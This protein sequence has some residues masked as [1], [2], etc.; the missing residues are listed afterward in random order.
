MTDVNGKKVSF[1]KVTNEVGRNYKLEIN[2]DMTLVTAEM[3]KPKLADH[4]GIDP[5]KQQ[6]LFKGTEISDFVS[7]DQL[8]IRP[9]DEL[10]LTIRPPETEYYTALI[11]DGLISFDGILKSIDFQ[12]ADL[13][14]QEKDTKLKL[15]RT[16]AKSLTRN[17]DLLRE[18]ITCIRA[19]DQKQHFIEQLSTLENEV[20]TRCWD[21]YKVDGSA[22]DTTSP[23]RVNPL[24]RL[25]PAQLSDLKFSNAMALFLQQISHQYEVLVTKSITSKLELCR[26]AMQIA[27]LW[28]A[29][30]TSSNSPVELAMMEDMCSG[31]GRHV[32]MYLPKIKSQPIQNSVE[33]VILYFGNLPFSPPASHRSSDD[34]M[35]LLNSNTATI[36]TAT[37]AIDA[38]LLS[39]LRPPSG[40]TRMQAA[41]AESS[42]SSTLPSKVSDKKIRN[43]NISSD[44][45]NDQNITN[46]NIV[47]N[48]ST[49]QNSTSQLV[50]TLD[51]VAAALKAGMGFYLFYFVF[52][53]VITF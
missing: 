30:V 27:A 50:L 42:L 19:V 20:Q 34:L 12:S 18:E 26:A 43:N 4:S 47:I 32:L 46:S 22:T 37:A 40:L 16:K 15:L 2:G 21:L 8:G 25:Q 44:I 41:P 24:K 13:P 49:E 3:L 39:D 45:H 36:E 17:I 23:K 10:K 38:V 7:F 51:D 52:K 1:L 31:A 14:P 53:R 29:S 35:R 6:L 11:N 5:K 9:D 28:E 33:E 48:E